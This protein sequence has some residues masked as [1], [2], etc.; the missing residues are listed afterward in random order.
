[1]ADVAIAAPLANVNNPLAYPPLGFDQPQ[2][3]RN[4]EG[5]SFYQLGSVGQ[6]S[7]A[8]YSIFIP[9]FEFRLSGNSPSAASSHSTGRL[10]IR[11]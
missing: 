1:L 7:A 9:F 4:A 8:V 5:F 3:G 11:P 10:P 2:A 6:H